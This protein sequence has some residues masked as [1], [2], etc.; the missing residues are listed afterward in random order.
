MASTLNDPPPLAHLESALER[1]ASALSIAV[2]R[3]MKMPEN[4]FPFERAARA[5]APVASRLDAPRRVPYGRFL[6]R[7]RD[8]DTIPIGGGTT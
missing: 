4:V 5:A 8:L 2:C 6:D 1:V 7:G 3:Q